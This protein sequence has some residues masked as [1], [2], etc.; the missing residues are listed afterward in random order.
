MIVLAIQDLNLEHVFK[1]LKEFFV[2]SK[3][4]PFKKES[5]IQALDYIFENQDY[6]FS[7]SHCCSYLGLNEHPV[8]KIIIKHLDTHMDK[9]I[10]DTYIEWRAHEARKRKS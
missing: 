6:I 5:T 9:N 4:K 8:K 2:I 7:F 3:S 10:S 1:S